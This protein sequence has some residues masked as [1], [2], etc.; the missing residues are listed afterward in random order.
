MLM[1]DFAYLP[2]RGV[3][4]V[5]GPDRVTFLNGLIS[6]DAARATP[7]SAVWA[8]LLTP[9]GRYLSDFFILAE[10]DRLLLDVPRETLETVLTRLKRYKLRANAELA[11]LSGTLRVYAA[12]NGTPPPVPVTAPDP[13]LPEAGYRCLT[14]DDLPTN[15]TAQDYD[16]HRLALG[17]PNGPPDLEPDKTLLLEAGFDELSGV[18]WDKG[19]YMGQELTARTKYRGLIKRRLVPVTLSASVPAG[20]PVM[21]GDTEIGTLRSSVGVQALATLRLD[22]LDKPLHAGGAEVTPQVPAWMRLAG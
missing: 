21:A 17:L 19:C 6:N 16:A 7:G 2:D 22:A 8:A 18:S 15:A 12:W 1:A 13:R 14:P 9:Q 3:I 4:S 5:T 11:D 10:E 20:T